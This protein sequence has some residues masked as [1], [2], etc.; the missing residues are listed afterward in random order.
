MKRLGCVGCAT[1]NASSAMRAPSR[2]PR[3]S[4][5]RA[6]PKSASAPGSGAALAGAGTNAGAPPAPPAPPTPPAPPDSPVDWKAAGVVGV[7]G[8][9][10][11][12]VDAQAARTRR[13]K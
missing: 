10:A 13:G 8:C 9:C 12:D 11:C 3:S 7:P 2:S 5:L 1:T 4:L 6:A